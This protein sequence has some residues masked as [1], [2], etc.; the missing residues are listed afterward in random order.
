MQTIQPITLATGVALLTAVSSPLKA[1]SIPAGKIAFVSASCA[2]NGGQPCLAVMN[3]DGT[4]VVELAGTNRF[5]L[6][7]SPDGSRI[8]YINANGLFVIPAAGGTPTMLVA[9]P[10]VYAPSW[11][12]DGTRIVLWNFGVIG[13]VPSSGGTITS[14]GAG[15]VPTWSPKAE[16]IAFLDNRE[17]PEF[18]ELY[19][20]NADGSGVSRLAPGVPAAGRPSWSADG[21]HIV[22][23]CH[24]SYMNSRVC[25]VRG[26]G[27]G[28]AVVATDGGVDS[29]M[30]SWSSQM[31]IAYASDAGSDPNCGYLLST[32][33]TIRAD[34]S[35]VTPLGAGAGD[36]TAVQ[37]PVWSPTADRI[38]FTNVAISY[39]EIHPPCDGGGACSPGY[40]FGCSLS[41]SVYV[42]NADG[43]NK[44]SLAAGYDHAWQ[45]ASTNAPPLVASFTA[46][47]NGGTCTF[48]AS[49]S[50]GASNYAWSFGDGASGSGQNATHTYSANA[51]GTYHVTLRA[52]SASGDTAVMSQPV[53]PVRPVASF[54][55]NC[56]GL[57]CT[58]DASS[59]HGN[60]VTYQWTFG[61]G[62]T[63]SGQVILHGYPAGA[64]YE[65]T[66]TVITAGGVTAVMSQSV[67][68]SAVLP[69]NV[70]PT[71]SFT[72][73]C[74]SLTCTFDASLSRD[75][76]GAIA[77]YEWNF[78][79]G[80][81]KWGGPSLTHTLRSPGTYA[82]TL[83]VYDARGTTAQTQQSVTVKKRR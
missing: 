42:M 29:A 4:S 65:A 61:D 70:P 72:V 69:P 19:A 12:P 36:W 26:D 35:G 79:Y 50:Q 8:A 73:A 9:G 62:I 64:T 77:A 57:I 51:D 78:G 2:S 21:S 14:L 55:F 20:M 80:P 16:R 67:T 3:S 32:V 43:T 46:A 54:T 52:F 23:T 30:P 82:V 27:S 44:V 76:D 83:T 49:S 60:I 38:A 63:G 18:L 53:V 75:P 66:L 68:A 15:I 10:E 34:G 1:Q 37:N 48:D 13:V 31:N 17:H 28:F 33:K 25:V 22:F 58:F 6:V 5:G 24:T 74:V 45:P 59:S 81:T 11:S 47:C 39:W 41:P 56:F 40:Y 7:W 71:A